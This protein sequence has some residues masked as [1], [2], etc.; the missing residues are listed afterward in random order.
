[1]RDFHQ[2]SSDIP[3]WSADGKSVFYTATVGDNV[4]LFQT[5]LDGKTSQLTKSPPATLHYHIKPSADGRWLLYG[6]KRDGVR[7]MFV[8]DV[9]S[10]RETQLTKLNRGHAA[11]WPHWQPVP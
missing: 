11:M 7:Q 1:M 5:S 10:G 6:S 3:V 9:K 2:G 4:E 8:T